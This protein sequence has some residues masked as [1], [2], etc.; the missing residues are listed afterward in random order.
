MMEIRSTKYL[1]A[2]NVSYR[3]AGEILN[4]HEMG[5]SKFE[6]LLELARFSNF[7]LGILDLFRVSEFGFRILAHS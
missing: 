4:K 5:N 2:E 6:L 3:Q 1:P 7:G